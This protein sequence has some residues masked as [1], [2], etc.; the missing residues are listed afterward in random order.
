MSI[1]SNDLKDVICI[2]MM[3]IDTQKYIEC[4][5]MDVDSDDTAYI[6]FNK[7]NKMEL[8]KMCHA[9]KLDISAC[10]LKA[11]FIEILQKYHNNGKIYETNHYAPRKTIPAAVRTA[12][13]NKWIGVVN[14]V[15][16]CFICG[17]LM[18]QS[19]F[20]CGHIIAHAKGGTTE[21]N[22]LKPICQRCNCSMGM[23]NMDDFI[24][25]FGFNKSIVY[26]V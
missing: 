21:I 18:T 8:I 20:H 25:K 24:K 1:K 5:M 2:D 6:N 10:K 9:H 13:W 3:E 22:N 26:Y 14:G 12:V 11:D 17:T 23:Q 19:T 4:D 16:K 7:L 15:G